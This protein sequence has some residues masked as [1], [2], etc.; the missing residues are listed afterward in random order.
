MTDDLVAFL[1]AR[2]DDEQRSAEGGYLRVILPLDFDG[3][4]REG[5]VFLPGPVKAHV[6]REIDAKRRNLALHEAE[7]GQHPDF[8]GYDKHE[9]P[10]PALRLAALPHAD[11]PDYRQKWRP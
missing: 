4:T 8:C 10:C 6:L 3:L 5:T 1:R 9:L 7:T 2:L 11:H